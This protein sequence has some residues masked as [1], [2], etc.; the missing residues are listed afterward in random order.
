[1]SWSC[2]VEAAERVVTHICDD[3]YVAYDI[4]ESEN[5]E[6]GIKA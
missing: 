2:R 5:L 6:A 3:T 1:M 4:M